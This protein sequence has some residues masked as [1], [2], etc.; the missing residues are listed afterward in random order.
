MLSFGGL[1][2][3]PSSSMIAVL[4]THWR[5]QWHA[6][7]CGLPRDYSPGATVRLV[8]HCEAGRYTQSF[9]THISYSFDRLR[10]DT[11]KVIR[12]ISIE[13]PFVSVG[14]TV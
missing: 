8:R 4:A 13:C 14:R 10:R 6:A 11:L 9:E 1:N 2:G 5:R 7:L 3:E 12:L